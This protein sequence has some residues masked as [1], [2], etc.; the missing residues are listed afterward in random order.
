MYMLYI[1]DVL[2][3]V[4]PGK[5]V[6]ETEMD[7][8]TYTLVDGSCV[9]Q[10]G[11]KGLRKISFDL[12]LPMSEYPFAQYEEGFCNGEYYVEHLNRIASE[13]S[14]VKFDV[15]RTYR[16]GSITYLTSFNVL[17]EKVT[18]TE[19]AGNGDD[20]KAGIVLREYRNIETVIATGKKTTYVE[21]EDTYKEPQTYTVQKGDSLWVISKKIYGDGAKYSYLA[22]LNGIKSPYVIY[23]GQVLKVKE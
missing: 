15:F 3:P 16:C 23:A 2:F 5:I 1:D 14:P 7:N 17:L 4:A 20:L 22:E 6:F 13:N 19:D 9:S 18:V 12:L 11:G 10:P 21:R 8:R